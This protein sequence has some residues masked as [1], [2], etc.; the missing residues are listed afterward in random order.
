[1]KEYG[2]SAASNY[3]SVGSRRAATEIRFSH[4]TDWKMGRTDAPEGVRALS[5]KFTPS[6]A[7]NCS[8]CWVQQP[9]AAGSNVDR[10]SAGQIVRRATKSGLGTTVPQLVLGMCHRGRL[11]PAFLHPRRKVRDRSS[12]YV[13]PVPAGTRITTTCQLFEEDRKLAVPSC[14]PVRDV[15]S[16]GDEFQGRRRFS[17]NAASVAASFN[18]RRFIFAFV[19]VGAWVS[20]WKFRHETRSVETKSP[21]ETLVPVFTSLISNSRAREI[22][23]VTWK[24]CELERVLTLKFLQRRNEDSCRSQMKWWG[25]GNRDVVEVKVV[26]SRKYSTYHVVPSA[27]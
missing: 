7:A 8:R 20:R 27:L 2:A 17:N 18:T 19:S 26:V 24:W 13:H 1:M 25:L 3:N 6:P 21:R 16:S 4:A 11:S 22:C 5:H 14:N 23:K 15:P 12:R 9:E 10:H